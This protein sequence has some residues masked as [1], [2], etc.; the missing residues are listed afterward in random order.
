MSYDAL[1]DALAAKL[2]VRLRRH[3]SKKACGPCPECG[4]EDRLVVWVFEE[5]AWCSRCDYRAFFGENLDETRRAAMAQRME[6]Q[7][8][9]E[10]IRSTISVSVDWITYNTYAKEHP[11]VWTKEGMTQSDITKWG[12]GYTDVCPAQPASR[13]LTI[14]VFWGDQLVDIRHKLL[15]ADE[16]SGK[17][18][19]HHPMLTPIPFNLNA[20]YT[21]DTVYIVEG[22]KK[23]IIMDRFGYSHTTGIPGINTAEVL[24]KEISKT[25]QAISNRYVVC[26]DPGATSKAESLAAA[27][28]TTRKGSVALVA[29]FFDKPDDMLLEYG[30]A[31]VEAIIKQARRIDEERSR[32]KH[33]ARILG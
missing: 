16:M 25:D 30:G 11:E 13:S 17:Y 33:P 9:V 21:S 28:M 27:I 22:E 15:D 19:S 3:T 24:L 6:Q 23:A 5:S 32:K 14:P 2:G 20:I 26:F 10:S 1:K 12:L 4:G 8:L 31:V 29:D 7:K 18:R